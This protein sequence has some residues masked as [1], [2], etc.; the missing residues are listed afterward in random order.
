[1]ATKAMESSQE[2]THARTEEEEDLLVMSNKKVKAGDS[3]KEGQP[4]DVL[5]AT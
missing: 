4:L 1:M 5:M 3:P 2:R